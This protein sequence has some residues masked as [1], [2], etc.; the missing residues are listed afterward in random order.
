[1]FLQQHVD[2][3]DIYYMNNVRV[4]YLQHPKVLELISLHPMELANNSNSQEYNNM[5][6][7]RTSS[8]SKQEPHQIAAYWD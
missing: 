8:H 1:M 6:V 3:V 2:S 4:R 5:D 7:R